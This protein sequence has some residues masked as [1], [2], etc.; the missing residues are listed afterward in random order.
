[1]L[2]LKACATTVWL[3][4]ESLKIEKK[5]KS[6]K[7]R[8]RLNNNVLISMCETQRLPSTKTTKKDFTNLL[9]CRRG[10]DALRQGHSSGW[11]ALRSKDWDLRH[12]F[13]NQRV[14]QWGECR[15]AVASK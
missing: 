6:K 10:D 3:I 14:R 5:K 8:L 4:F 2:G 12:S 13:M 9:V 1:V 7:P 11:R 15:H